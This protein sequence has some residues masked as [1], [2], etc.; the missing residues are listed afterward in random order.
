MN[1]NVSSNGFTQ[2]KL[3]GMMMVVLVF[4]VVQNIILAYHGYKKLRKVN[5]VLTLSM[6]GNVSWCVRIHDILI[7]VNATSRPSLEV[8]YHFAALAYYPSDVEY[9]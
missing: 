8:T 5:I 3:D 4:L 9:G 7:N 1:L 2:W 6:I